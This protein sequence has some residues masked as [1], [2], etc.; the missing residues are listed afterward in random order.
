MNEMSRE[1]RAL[2][3]AGRQGDALHAADKARIRSKL[4][5]RIGAG[6]A[7]GSA[8]TVS[9]AVAEAAHVTWL[10]SVAAWLPAAAKVLGIVA[11]AGAVS[12]GVVSVVHPGAF[13]VPSRVSPTDQAAQVPHP[14]LNSVP[15][16]PHSTAAVQVDRSVSDESSPS[17]VLDTPERAVAVHREARNSS[18]PPMNG[19][20]TPTVDQVPGDDSLSSQVSAIREARAA[21]RRGDSRAALAALDRAQGQGGPLEQEVILA[22]VSALCLQ[23]D[24]T[25]AR[26]AA[27]QFLSRYPDSLLAP[28]IRSSCAFGSVPSP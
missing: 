11:A 17:Q 7:L 21:L 25:A 20:A 26:R 8:V 16:R 23:G 10:A 27:D 19:E 28:R 24:A 13:G 12:V 14:T 2:I 22:R 9:T 15:A 4:T 3:A 5:H 6:L 1:S 18:G